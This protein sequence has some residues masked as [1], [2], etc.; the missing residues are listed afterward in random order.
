MRE[1]YPVEELLQQWLLLP[2]FADIGMVAMLLR[3]ARSRAGLSLAALL[4]VFAVKN[5][6]D[7]WSGAL[8]GGQAGLACAVFIGPLLLLFLIAYSGGKRLAGRMMY[9]IGLVLLP[10]FL[11][12]GAALALGWPISHPA[13]LAFSTAFFILAAALYAAVLS[14]ET[15][16]GKEPTLIGAALM[17]LFISGPVYDFALSGM[18]P[19]TLFPYTSAAAGGLLVFCVLK[20]KSFSV[21]P[22]AE[23]HLEGK[24]GLAAEPGLYL[25]R[26]DRAGRA[27]ELFA[28]AVRHGVPGLAVTRAHPAAFRR[29]TGLKRIP[30]IWLAQSTYEKSLPPGEPEVLLHALRDHAL[31]CERSVVLLENLDY[32]ITNAGLYQTFDLLRNLIRTSRRS[33]AVFLLVSELLTDDER[34][35]LAELGVK[36]LR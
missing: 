2:L 4:S 5:A 3:S 22:A 28:D 16:S 25:T 36:P 18:M 11:F 34:R 10:A 29:Q 9:P 14:D 24:W 33:D 12:L 8:H 21:Y 31:R 26:K 13:I 27:R 19:L 23:E 17:L 15:L 7:L 6:A 1:I 20:Y 35:E 30:M 32:L